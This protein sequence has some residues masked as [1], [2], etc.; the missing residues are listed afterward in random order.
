MRKTLPGEEA[1]HL[2]ETF[3]F[4]L[5]LTKE[6]AAAKGV[7]VDEKGYEKAK[8][9]AQEKSRSYADEFTKGKAVMMQKIE[10]GYP[11]TEF[12]GYETLTDEAETLALLNENLN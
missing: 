8:E 4:P 11:A 7:E 9:A 1:F 10:N 2:H 3:G 12:T 6:I 5:E